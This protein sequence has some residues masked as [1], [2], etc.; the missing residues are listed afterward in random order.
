MVPEKTRLEDLYSYRILDTTPE[1]ELDELTEIASLVFNVPISLITFI[2]NDRQWFKS[3]TGIDANQTSREDS[4]CRHT[5][6]NPKE[7]LV[8]KDSLKDLRFRDNPLVT[9]DPNIRFYAGAPLETPTG[10]VLGTLCVI[11]NQPREITENEQ[12]VLQILA[13]KAMTYLNTRKLLLSQEEEISNHTQKLEKLT[14]TVPGGI[15]Q[16]EMNPDG[17]MNFDFLSSG[18]KALHPGIDIEEWKKNPEIG[19]STVHPD[20]LAGLQASMMKSFKELTVWYHEYRADGHGEYKWHLV[21]ANPERLP[22]GNVVWYGSF[23]D[24]TARV[25]YEKAMEQIAFDIS[26][27]LRRPVTSLM[28]LTQLVEIEKGISK[29]QLQEY[30]DHIKTTSHEL[31]QFTRELNNVYQI[32]RQKI[33]GSSNAAN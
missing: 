14:D 1:Q 10:S 29:A 21:K 8:V 9:E 28:G 5:L 20:D 18:M 6:N 25:E 11:D 32:K 23:Q 12:R 30:V 15:F 24:I 7:V 13:R 2:D 22:N 33:S 3:K 27:V 17:K 4:F 31:D 16:L 19:F 26:H